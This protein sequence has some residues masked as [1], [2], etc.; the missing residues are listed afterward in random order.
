MYSWYLKSV[1]YLRLD[2]FSGFGNTIVTGGNYNEKVIGDVINI[3]GH[4]I[5]FSNQNLP[6]FIVKISEI[7]EGL[8]DQGKSLEQIRKNLVQ[9]LSMASRRNSRFNQKFIVWKATLSSNNIQDLDPNILSII[10]DTPKASLW[11]PLNKRSTIDED[12]YLNLE[13]FLREGRWEDADNE[14]CEVLKLILTR[15]KGEGFPLELNRRIEELDSDYGFSS[16]MLSY[17]TFDCNIDGLSAED[18]IEIPGN[19]LKYL[20]CLWVKYSG[21]RF[22]FSIQKSI[23]KK[24]LDQH[25]THN[26]AVEIFGRKIGFIKDKQWIYYT[27][28]KYS[29]NQPTGYLPAKVLI[30]GSRYSDGKVTICGEI[31]EALYGRQ[32]K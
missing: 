5:N 29:I 6:E 7:I 25:N 22:G 13:I 3:Q 8:Q 17:S 18:I 32:Y 26:N 21:G 14:T 23:L 27:D 16:L 2:H 31:L 28:L 1:G 10:T 19:Y 30:S 9:D 15:V 11:L 4:V 12:I 20:D 24:I